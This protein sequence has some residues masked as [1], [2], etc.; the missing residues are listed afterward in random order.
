VGGTNGGSRWPPTAIAQ[1]RVVAR[2]RARGHRL[3]QIR[4][5][6]KQGLLAYG[7]VEDLFPAKEEGRSVKEVAS[8]VGLEP[9]LI[10][11][12][13]A[14]IGL[15]AQRLENLGAEDVEALRYVASVFSS[16][17]CMARRSRRSPTPKPACSTS[18]STS[19]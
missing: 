7:F 11:R 17:A 1:A 12:I 9:A 13:W 15:P 2:L 16:V 10:E 19:R 4:E 8:E 14:G 3:D 18:M 5:A 6:S